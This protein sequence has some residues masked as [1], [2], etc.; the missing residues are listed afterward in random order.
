MMAFI[1]LIGKKHL[2]CQKKSKYA[3]VHVVAINM[4]R[5]QV[6]QRTVNGFSNVIFLVIDD[7]S[8]V[9]ELSLLALIVKTHSVA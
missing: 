5:V 8:V 6:F 1:C 3:P 7:R 2:F 4:I 9:G